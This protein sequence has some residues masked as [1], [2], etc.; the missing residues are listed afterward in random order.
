MTITI[1]TDLIQGGEAWLDARKGK[2]CASEVCKILT[3][4]T[5]KFA[6][7]DQMR[8][9][10]H[11]LLAQRITNYIEPHYVSDSMLRGHEDEMLA[12]YTYSEKYE[13]VEEA[14]FIT[15]NA[16]GFEIGY[17]PDGLVGDDG[18]IEVKSRA[19]RFQIETILA[20]EMPDEFRLQ[21]QTA[22]LVS[23]RKWCDFISYSGGLPMMTVRVEPD[24]A[25][26]AA[27]I[28]AATQFEAALKKAEIRYRS[29]L[30]SDL[31]LIPT[32]RRV[33]EEMVI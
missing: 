6:Q 17:S 18:L 11:E 31:R 26:Q 16:W 23:G 27:I 29:Q 2:I 1:H 30:N 25:V 7:N 32:E 8:A 24:H 21:V 28:D 10:H 22:L 33:E 5:L 12:R 13:P 19:Q 9:H 20:G 15:N 14:G 4:K 3:A